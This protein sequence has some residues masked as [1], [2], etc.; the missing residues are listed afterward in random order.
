MDTYKMTIN[1]R[2]RRCLIR[3][4]SFQLQ[5]IFF[6]C[7]CSMLAMHTDSRKFHTGRSHGNE[8]YSEVIV[9]YAFASIV[10][11]SAMKDTHQLCSVSVFFLLY[12]HVLYA[13][14]FMH[15]TL[16]SNNNQSQ[17]VVC[18]L[19]FDH[20]NYPAALLLHP[21]NHLANFLLCVHIET[22]H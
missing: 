18:W 4:G 9:P 21:F 13:R 3:L 17:L 22:S 20:L 7:F 19:I 8:Q 1:H 12:E 14:V 11:C 10:P 2:I 6:W 16:C 15:L 5:W